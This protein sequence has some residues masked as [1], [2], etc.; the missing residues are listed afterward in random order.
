MTLTYV[1]VR[2]CVSYLIFTFSFPLSICIDGPSIAVSATPALSAYKSAYG[3]SSSYYSAPAPAVSKVFAAPAIATYGSAPT[4]STYSSAPAVSSYYSSNKL[5]YSTP[6][7]IKQVSYASAAP[8]LQYVSPAISTAHGSAYGI[9][10]AAY[11]VAP[12]AKYVS[13][14][15]YTNPA[16]SSSYVAAN[17]FAYTGPNVATQYA[18]S[19][20]PSLAASYVSAPIAKQVSYA[21]NPLLAGGGGAAYVS[22]YNSGAAYVAPASVATTLTGAGIVKTAGYTSSLG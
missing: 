21:T 18:A 5:A 14:A 15:A 17:K 4:V 16:Y 13:T 11:S 6:S 1:C 8:P 2:V 3:L 9:A 7:L 19:Y 10:K 12:A 20:T 22:G